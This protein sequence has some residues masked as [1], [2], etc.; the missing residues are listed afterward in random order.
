MDGRSRV[1]PRLDLTAETVD[2]AETLAMQN[3]IT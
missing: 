3:K 2:Q 1:D